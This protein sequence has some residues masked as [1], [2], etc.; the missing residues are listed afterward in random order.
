MPKS[1]LVLLAIDDEQ[2]LQLFE[3]ALA[4]GSY[5]VAVARDHAALDMALQES[6]P[7]LIIISQKFDK[8]DELEIAANLL[9][10]FPTLPILLF[11]QQDSPEALRKQYT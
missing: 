5:G 10:R 7:A 9:E 4:A 6:S 1:D 3:R 8:A 11:F 2:I